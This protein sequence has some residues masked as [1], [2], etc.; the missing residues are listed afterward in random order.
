V[1]MALFFWLV[2]MILGFATRWLLG[3]G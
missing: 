3:Q 2:D 1:V